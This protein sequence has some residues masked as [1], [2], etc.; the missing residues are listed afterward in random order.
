MCAIVRFGGT[1]LLVGHAD[2]N[3]GG[4]FEI[5]ERIQKCPEASDA[6][7][8]TDDYAVRIQ[9]S[10]SCDVR[11]LVFSAEWVRRVT[12]LVRALDEGSFSTLSV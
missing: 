2:V 7:E 6:D 1:V 11:A 4:D 5:L 12:N 8:R 9:D 3:F 10:G